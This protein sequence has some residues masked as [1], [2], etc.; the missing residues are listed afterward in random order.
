MREITIQ[1]QVDSALFLQLLSPEEYKEISD[2]YTKDGKSRLHVVSCAVSTTSSPEIQHS[3]CSSGDDPSPSS[4]VDSTSDGL[5]DQ[6]LLI[7]SCFSNQASMKSRLTN[8]IIPLSTLNASSPYI[9]T[10][11]NS[12][13]LTSITHGR[14]NE[15]IE[16]GIYPNYEHFVGYRLESTQKKDSVIRGLLCV[17]D[18]AAMDNQKLS[19]INNMMETVHMRCINELNQ[20]QSQEQLISARDLAV[21]DAEN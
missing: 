11:L 21:L 10:L 3:S 18:H 1:A 4:N 7:R 12:K 8:A 5:Q 20:L 16:R 13:K 14:D 17:T 9:K 19:I 2:I 6:F 15:E